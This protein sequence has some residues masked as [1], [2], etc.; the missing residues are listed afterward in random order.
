MARKWIVFA[1]IGLVVTI[2]FT[3]AAI[4]RNYVQYNVMKATRQSRENESG[5]DMKEKTGQRKKNGR[6]ER[7]RDGLGKAYLL[8]ALSVAGAS[9]A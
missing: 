7:W 2:G 3:I 6:V 1:S 9:L 5:A 8:P 4:I